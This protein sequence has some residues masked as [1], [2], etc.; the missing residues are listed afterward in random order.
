MGQKI[1]E[2]N[3]TRNK[4]NKCLVMREQLEKIE[5]VSSTKNN[6]HYNNNIYQ[7]QVSQNNFSS[8]FFSCNKFPITIHRQT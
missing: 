6:Y 2:M 8:A 4:Y 7:N 1:S 3:N 5:H